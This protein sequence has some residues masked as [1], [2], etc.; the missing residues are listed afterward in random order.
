MNITLH[1]LRKTRSGSTLSPIYSLYLLADGKRRTVHA[2]V[3]TRQANGIRFRE[4]W[5]DSL[6]AL[7]MDQGR[8]V[9]QAVSEFHRNRRLP[10]FPLELGNLDPAPLQPKRRTL[11]PAG[12]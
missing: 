7:N 6:L 9:Y 12:A 8:C 10:K 3:R 4:A 11:V 2:T 1:S 5:F